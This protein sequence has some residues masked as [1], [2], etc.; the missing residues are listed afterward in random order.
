[1]TVTLDWLGVATFRLTID[2]LVNETTSNLVLPNR[3]LGQKWPQSGTITIESTSSN[4]GCSSR[5]APPRCGWS[6]A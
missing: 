4:P 3:K 1:M 6:I 2:D 5:Q